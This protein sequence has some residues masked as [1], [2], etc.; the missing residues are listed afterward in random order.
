M[1]FLAIVLQQ[2][3]AQRA[4]YQS[5][6]TNVY[7]PTMNHSQI[8]MNDGPQG[9]RDNAHLGSTTSWPSGLTVASS[10]DPE[11]AGAWGEAMGEE[12]RDKGSNVQ[13]GPGLCVARVPRNGR[14]FECECK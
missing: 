9:F 13:L 1:H 7:T 3:L 4:F 6:A 8:L 14:N 2:L 5:L 10:W 11:L 12:F